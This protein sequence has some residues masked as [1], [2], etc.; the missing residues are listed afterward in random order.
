MNLFYRNRQL[1]LLTLVLIVVWGLSAFLTLPRLEDPEIVQR[2]A[3]VTTFLPGA[4]PERVETLVTEKIEDR[5]FELEEIESLRSTSGSGISV[6][7]VEL[8]DT[9]PDVD[10]VWAKVRSKVDDAVPELPAAASVPEYAD[11]STKASALIVGLTWTRDDAPN[12]AIMGRL[13]AALEDR[14]RAIPGTETVE[15]FGEPDEEIRV[16]IAATEL[17]RLGL[18]AAALSQQ[19]A[20]SDAKVSAGQFRS[21]SSE[22]LLEV[23]SS[24]SSLE[25]I[26]AI[27]IA[28]GSEGQ[29]ARLGDIATVTKAVQDPPT[30]LALVNG[31]GAIALSAKVESAQRVDQ[32]AAQARAVLDDF[33]RELPDGLD[34][35]VVLDQ[36]Q[37]VQQRLN[38]VISNL[39]TGSLL[40]IGVSL[41]IL[42]WKSALLVGLALPLTTL[43]VFGTMKVLGVPLHQ[44]SVTGVIIALGLLI[45][46]AI[47]VVD[48]VQGRLRAGMAPGEAVAQTVHHLLVPLLASTLTTVLAFIPIASSPGGVGEFIGTIGLTVIL[49]LLSSLALSLTVIVSLVA[50]LH[51]WNPLPWRWG[52]WQHGFSNA[53][54]ANGYRWTLRAVFRRPWLGVGLSLILPVI[55]F[56]VFATLPQQFFPPTNRN[57]F[58]I[59]FELP[60]Q[61]TLDATQTQIRQVRQ[62]ALQHPEIDDVHWFMGRSAP[63]FFYNVLD[64]RRNA[65][66]YAQGIVHL[67]STNNLRETI[68]SLQTELDAAFPQAQVLVKQ[69]EQGPPFDAPIEL[70]VYGADLAG[71]RAVGDR[72]RAELA[73]VPD[74]VH[75]R[76]TLTE[77]LP[78][79]A[80]EVDETQAR[81]LGLDNQ[82]IAGQLSAALDGRTGGSVLDGSRDI[83]VR[84]RV[85]GEQQGNLGA[86]ASLDLVTPQGELPLDAIA[87]LKLVPDTAS[88][89]RRNGQRINTVQGF[90][91]AGALP[92]TVLSAFQTR[93]QEQGFELPPGYRIE[94]GGEAD[95]R[96]TAVGNLLSTVGVLG[97]LMTATLVLSFNSFGL[98]AL[99]GSVA[100]LA[101]GLAAL[102]L[103][104][105]GS[106]FGFTA[107]LGTLGLI[108]LAI[109]DSIVVLAALR[110]HPEARLGHPQATEDVVFQATRH[111]IATTVTTIIGF[112]PLMVD[113]TGFWPPL[114]IAIA[115]GLGGATLL[116]L[117]YIPSAYRLLSYRHPATVV[118]I[119]AETAFSKL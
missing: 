61:A 6:I 38:G 2:F 21:D 11:S 24:L 115:G 65:Q 37:Y 92:S 79:L 59:E 14:L 90:I 30:D 50:R 18:S 17:S 119:P 107:I 81:R 117:Y 74:V 100:V 114:A 31:Q 80:L 116:A 110:E 41:L 104:L 66:N 10:P 70:R 43:M 63:P 9:I 91:T 67:V 56:A 57:Q 42:G 97:I 49:A 98:A 55:G 1:L 40:V 29:V 19:I 105:F 71:L 88:I 34:L 85:P 28:A 64:N 75:T 77:A 8:K 86:I 101:V 76:A 33:R 99:I 39:I 25:Q 118:Q 84:V 87:S 83:P 53:A 103:K 111:V 82:A 89:S 22:F 4:T 102:A 62:L 7:T 95:A 54:L 69:L 26:R 93:L 48:E 78:K 108:G 94:Y 52:W 5:L 73:Q 3:R 27:P 20:A 58:Q 68:Q 47:I 46:N 96:G 109:N 16:D 72:L 13:A 112:V 51:R 15:I 60:T 44:M 12:Y 106:I 113:P 45:D 32:W 23:N 35:Q 36:S